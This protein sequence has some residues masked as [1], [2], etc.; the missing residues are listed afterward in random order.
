MAAAK[1]V[2]VTAPN[3]HT[4][5][6]TARR[7]LRWARRHTQRAAHRA[8]LLPKKAARQVSKIPGA[9]AGLRRWSVRGLVS[10]VVPAYNV[11]AYVAEC[12]ASLQA[13]TWRDIEII[14]VIDGATDSTE[15]IVR[16]IAAR[17][18]RIRVHT[19]DN[20][21]LSA[22]RNVGASLARGQYLWFLDS[23]DR[24]KPQTVA[25][26][27][28]SLRRTGSEVAI[29][30]YRRFNSQR[31]KHA[32]RWVRQ[33]HDGLRRAINPRQHPDIQVNQ[34]AW[35]KVYQR[36]FWTRHK[37]TFPV[38]ALYEDQPVSARLYALAGRVDILPDVLQ[39]WRD[40]EDGS[41]ISQ[42]THT[43]RDVRARIA[44]ATNSLQTLAD[45]DAEM[46]AETRAIQLLA[47]DIPHSMKDVGAASTEFLSELG[48][49]IGAIAAYLPENGWQ[50]IPA[51]HA[52]LMYLLMAQDEDRVREYVA[53]GG[54][55]PWRW[56]TAVRAGHVILNVPFF[57]D[58]AAAIPTAAL[59]LAP[60][61]RVPIV[62]VRQAAWRAPGVLELRG[63]AR[64]ALGPPGTVSAQLVELP[65][66]GE[67]QLH[68]TIE[69][70][71]AAGGGEVVPLELGS[72]AAQLDT[73]GEPDSEPE[74]AYDYSGC[75]FSAV[76]DVDAL[77]LRGERTYAIYFQVE[78]A[79]GTGRTPL[80]RADKGVIRQLGVTHTARGIPVRLAKVDN[81]RLGVV[82]GRRTRPTEPTRSTRLTQPPSA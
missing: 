79:A 70:Q 46:L 61:D 64:P 29:F 62:I 32:G 78:S 38:G 11:E 5:V 40:R 51:A 41:S 49:G 52:A 21:G 22:A 45:H 54:L 68:M 77:E 15:Q 44:A 28:A 73:P 82:L 58:P 67:R 26:A 63:L 13:Q 57:D 74:W 65:T 35:S 1:T 55:Q 24:V 19:Q 48:R 33:A 53:R 23:D 10:I 76:V 25:T 16:E 12:L 43:L 42:Q 69:Q 34:V 31:F 72:A 39:D 56:P 60:R 50:H 80:F 59:R 20:A 6:A 75:G 47:N 30:C 27:L 8:S 17:D 66:A 14:V 4:V 7:G 36:E 37:F 81:L 9:P 18:R 2:T 3:P 71:L